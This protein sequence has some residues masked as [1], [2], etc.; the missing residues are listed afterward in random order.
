[1]KISTGSLIDVMI[2]CKC[3]STHY[4]SIVVQLSHQYYLKHRFLHRHE[5]LF[6]FH[7]LNDI[8]LIMINFLKSSAVCVLDQVNSIYDQQLISLIC[9]EV[10]HWNVKCEKPETKLAFCSLVPKKYYKLFDWVRS[11]N[12]PK[13]M[14]VIRSLYLAEVK[15]DI[16]PFSFPFWCNPSLTSVVVW[17]QDYL[18]NL[19]LRV[20]F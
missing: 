5:W 1:M 17:F 15:R 11:C 20:N 4:R 8:T 12:F 6:F 3:I 9:V 7:L 18:R 2:N 13:S 10:Q 19:Y 14:C 16:S